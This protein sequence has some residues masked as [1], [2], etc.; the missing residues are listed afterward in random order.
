MWG[1]DTR[2]VFMSWWNYYRSFAEAVLNSFNVIPG[3]VG[4]E[5][6][7]CPDDIHD[8]WRSFMTRGWFD[9]ESEGY[10]NC[11]PLQLTQAP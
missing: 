4:P 7:P 1:R 5:P 9:W 6:P 2:D 11:S 10:P 3:R 8:Y